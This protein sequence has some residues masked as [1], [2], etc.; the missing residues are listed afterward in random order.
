MFLID[1]TLDMKDMI[2][3]FTFFLLSLKF[4]CDHDKSLMDPC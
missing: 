3:I 1:T 2:Q 4:L